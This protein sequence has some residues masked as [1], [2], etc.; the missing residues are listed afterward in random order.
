MKT[1]IK[2]TALF[3]L[4]STSIFA[5][6]PPK[7]VVPAKAD[8][9]TFSSLRSDRGINVKVEKN[10]P[11]KAVVAIY[12]QDRNMIRKDVLA[13]NKSLEKAYILNKLD[14]GDY[15]IE[16]TSNKQVVKK[17]IHVY[18]EGENKMFIVKQ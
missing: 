8:V 18:D 15:T 1:S 17:D 10:A 11:G 5:A 14:N 2:L 3:L 7:T 12:D 6:T 4:A 9:I 16:V 13:S